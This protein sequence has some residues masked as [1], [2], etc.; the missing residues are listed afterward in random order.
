MLEAQ[1]DIQCHQE[2]TQ[3]HSSITDRLLEEKKAVV[4]TE[5]E[6]GTMMI[7]AALPF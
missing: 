4:G 7:K 5:M 3:Y 2:K 1:F 6:S